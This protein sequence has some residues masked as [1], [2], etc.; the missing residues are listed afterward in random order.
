MLTSTQGAVGRGPLNDILVRDRDDSRGPWSGSNAVQVFQDAGYIDIDGE[1]PILFTH[2]DL[3]PCNILVTNGPNPRVAAVIDWAQ[4][5]WYP[6]YWEWCKAKWV[7]MWP[8][9]M[10]DAA[11]ELWREQYLPLVMDPLPEET[12]YYPW[13][14]YALANL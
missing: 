10:D 2:D 12:V 1:T 7:D 11:Q 13:L 8:D 6:S 4:A 14:R 5:G 3:V 9:E